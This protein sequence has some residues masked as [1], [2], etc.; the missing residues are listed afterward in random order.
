MRAITLTEFGGPSVMYISEVDTPKIKVDQ[1]LIRV[2]AFALNRAD[3]LQ[4]AG[5]YPPPPGESDIMGLEVAGEIVEMG[6]N[7][8]GWKI[9][10]RVCCLVGGGG[11]A[12]YCKSPAE[13]L[14]PLPDH[15]AYTTAAGIPEAFLT[16]WQSVS[17]IAKLQSTDKILIHAGASGVGLSAIQIAKYIG[18]KVAITA[19]AQKHTYCTDAGADLCIDYKSESFDQIISEKWGQVDVI[20]DF[21]GGSYLEANMNC[22]ATEGRIVV[23]GLMGGWKGD[24]NLAHLLRKRVQVI[25]ST[26]RARSHEY[27]VELTKDL[28]EQFYP[29][30]KAGKAGPRIDQIDSWSNIV[31][32]HTRMEA[33]ENAGKI[34]MKVD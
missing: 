17:W 27:K 18:A 12:E 16:A 2:Y 34:I 26:L 8:S 4:R 20:I 25:G 15:M 3:T 9:G 24:L 14:I 1:V 22:I 31:A 11:Y 28:V 19:S 5:K 30:I 23:L 33:N 10:D 32:Q 7:V 6:A 29:Q 21:I 13:M